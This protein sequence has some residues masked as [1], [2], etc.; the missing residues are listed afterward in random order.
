MMDEMIVDENVYEIFEICGK[1]GE[2]FYVFGCLLFGGGFVVYFCKNY[3]Q[4]CFYVVYYYGDFDLNDMCCDVICMVIG[5]IG[6]GFEKIIFFIMG[7]VV[8]N[9]G[10][11]LNKWDENC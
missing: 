8:N 9:G 7:F 11:V 2:C 5:L 6:D 4:S 10:I 3:G 1:Q